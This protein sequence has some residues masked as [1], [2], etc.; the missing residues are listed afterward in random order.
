MF[1][2]PTHIR[3]TFIPEVPNATFSIGDPS[4]YVFAADLA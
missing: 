3:V 2:V 4:L 1:Q